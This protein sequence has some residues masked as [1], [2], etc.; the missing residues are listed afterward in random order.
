[1]YRALSARCNF[2]ARDKTDIGFKSK[3]LCREF[4]VPG[5]NSYA[6]LKRLVHYLVGLLGLVNTFSCQDL[7]TNVDIYTDT[8]F[9]RCK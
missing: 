2:L 7:L 3:E 4:A 8:D 6:E 9:A 5:R 1:M